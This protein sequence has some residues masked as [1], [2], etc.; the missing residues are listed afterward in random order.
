MW[1]IYYII[2]LSILLYFPATVWK[3]NVRNATYLTITKLNTFRFPNENYAI[4]KLCDVLKASKL[5]N[6]KNLNT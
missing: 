5:P 3:V 4:E 2:S 6:T 1:L